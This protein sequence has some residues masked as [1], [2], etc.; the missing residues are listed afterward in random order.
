MSGPM[1]SRAGCVSHAP[2]LLSHTE[3]V[4]RLVFDN[5]FRVVVVLQ[6]FVHHVSI[7]ETRHDVFRTVEMILSLSRSPG[8][9]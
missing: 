3:V 4:E 2:V 1:P 8:P 9:R 6:I 5:I 7:P